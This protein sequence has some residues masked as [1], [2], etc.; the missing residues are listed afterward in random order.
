LWLI[1]GGTQSTLEDIKVAENAGG[2][3]YK[4]KNDHNRFIYW[5]T[6]QDILEISEISLDA[7]LRNNN[8]RFK[9]TD[10]PVLTVGIFETERRIVI[11]VGTVN[12]IHRFTLPHP[13]DLVQGDD[14]VLGGISS[15]SAMD[16]STFHLLGNTIGHGVPHKAACHYSEQ[17]FFG[18]AF[19]NTLYVFQMDCRTGHVSF[20]ELKISQ[21]IPR[22]LTNFS[23]V[24]RGK[25]GVDDSHYVSSL[26]FG[27]EEEDALVLY[28]LYR[29]NTLRMWSMRS[30]QCVSTVNCAD[31]SDGYRCQGSE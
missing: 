8:I 13:R 30:G 25:G 2:Y 22:I 15:E 9:F 29:D 11:L 3:C 18:Y 1:P 26:C 5:R 23:D 24:L 19:A 6:V 14:S 12:S 4:Y 17:A 31:K 27:V 7:N 10:S 16:P 21:M 20:S 28:S